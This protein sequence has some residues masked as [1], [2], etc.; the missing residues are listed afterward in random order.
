MESQI[1]RMVQEVKWKLP[2]NE[3]GFTLCRMKNGKLT[4]G[5]IATGT[6]VQVN[7]PVVCPPGSSLIGLL[8]SHPGGVAVP[9][10][11][12]TRSAKQLGV[13]DMCIVDDHGLRCGLV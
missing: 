12:D 7:I 10:P 13:K 8:H 3:F 5:P 6:P 2:K 1:T 4:R 11:Q 9:S